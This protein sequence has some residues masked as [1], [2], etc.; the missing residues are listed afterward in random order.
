M[1]V[2]GFSAQGVGFGGLGVGS[3]CRRLARLEPQSRERLVLLRLVP[4]LASCTGESMLGGS[5]GQIA[6]WASIGGEVV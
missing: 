2:V 6:A 3:P 4:E 5:S 1:W